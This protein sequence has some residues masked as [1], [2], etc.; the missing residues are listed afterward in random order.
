MALQCFR[1]WAEESRAGQLKIAIMNDLNTRL[2]KG[3][4]GALGT[5]SSI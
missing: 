4:K 3:V 1:A 2:T 5:R